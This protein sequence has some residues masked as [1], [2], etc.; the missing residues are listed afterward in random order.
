MGKI[1]DEYQICKQRR[2]TPSG[3]KV[4]GYDVC[5]FCRTEFKHVTKVEERHIPR[6][7]D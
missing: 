4:D 5:K 6:E 2:H 3:A 7:R 1:Y